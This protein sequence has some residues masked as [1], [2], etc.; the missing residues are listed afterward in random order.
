VSGAA[1]PLW[2][3]APGAQPTDISSAL[4]GGV[5]A[6]PAFAG[7][8]VSGGRLNVLRSLRMVADVGV[9]CAHPRP[10]AWRRLRHRRIRVVPRGHVVLTYHGRDLAAPVSASLSAHASWKLVLR[11]NRAGRRCSGTTGPRRS[12]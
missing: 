4:L 2:T 12:R 10:R 5:D 7:R 9:G 3:A 1:A 6:L 11:L 8:T